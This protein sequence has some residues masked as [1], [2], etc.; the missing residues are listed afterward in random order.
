MPKRRAG[1]G[2]AE[3]IGDGKWADFFY[4]DL[5][6]DK[7]LERLHSL[8]F[9]PVAGGRD[10]PF[11]AEVRGYSGARDSEGA[12][13]II[14][15]VDS[16]EALSYRMGEL[17]YCLDFQLETLSAPTLLVGEKGR[18]LRA[19]KVVA[20]AMQISSYD[21]LQEPFRRT[22]ANDLIN[23]WWTCDED[24]NPN[25]YLV[26]HAAG[27]QALVVAIDFN[28]ADLLSEGLKITGN[29]TEFGWHRE[30]KTR[31]LTLLKPSNFQMYGIEDF[32]ERLGLMM[33][34][35]ESRLKELARR[36]LEGVVK[37]PARQAQRLTR[38]LVRRRE[39]ID[40][41]FRKWFGPK[42]RLAGKSEGAEYESLGRAFVEQYK[43]KI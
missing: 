26:I 21:Y 12:L 4:L 7:L 32:Q 23:R 10:L 27:G 20:P 30:E 9:Q 16:Q 22:L 18:W 24:R 8:R 25:N 31:F 17:V 33:G 39:H 3:R 35:P 13:W 5:T 37:D 42:S 11:N 6:A 38:I 28:K 1:P 34:I 19:T 29:K 2:W 43:K 14:K 41:Y 40:T 36:L 15:P